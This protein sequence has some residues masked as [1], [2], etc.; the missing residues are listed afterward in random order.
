MQMKQA[1][2]VSLRW[3]IVLPLFS[4]VLIIAMVGAYFLANSLSGNIAV[5]QTNI[6]MESSRAVSQRIAALY[7]RQRIEAQG[8][9]FTIGVP[10]AITSGRAGALYPSM[11]AIASRA[12]LDSIIVT[13]AR[14]MEIVGIQR[15]D[16]PDQTDYAISTE[17]DLSNEIII[18]SVL[19]DGYIGATGLMNTTEGVLLFTA[20]PVNTDNEIIGV[21]LVG[22]RIDRVISEIHDGAI[23]DVALYGPDA[24]LM[25]SSFAPNDSIS[26]ALALNGGLFDQASRAVQNI[27]VQSF[28]IGKTLYQGAYFPFAFGPNIL[29]VIG[30]VMPDNI[31]FATEMGRQLT[32]LMLAS[33]AAV[34]VVGLFVGVNILIARMNRITQTA[35][36]L[37]AGNMT[38]RTGMK[39]TDEIGALGQALDQY[40]DYVQGRQDILRADLRRQ[41]RETT[42]LLAVLESLPD[43]IVVQD[44]DGRV[45]LMND[46]AKTLIGS[47]HISHSPDLH[48]LI[49]HVTNVLGPALAPGLYS[50]GSPQQID[51]D[52]KMLSAQA[53]AVMSLTGQRVGTVVVIR[54]ITTD[55]QRER[56]RDKILT[57]IAQEIQQP[58]SALS[59]PSQ[60]SPMS[61][62]AREITRHAVALQKM[63]VEMRELADTNLRDMPEQR[64]RPIRLDT[65]VWSVANEWRQ[66]A[67]ANNLTLHV[68]IEKA[69][70]HVLGNERRLRWAIGNIIDNAIKYT[71]PGGALTLEIRDDISEGRAHLRVRDNGVGIPSD[72]L[73]NVLTRFYRGN[74]IT[75]EGRAI[76]VPGTGQGLSSA[77][78]IFEAH[79]GALTIKSKQWVGTAVYFTIPLTAPVGLEIPGLSADMEGE[80]VRIETAK[81][82]RLN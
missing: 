20:V 10:E 68:I 13:D 38:A 80:T 67:Q 57:Q 47:Q 76:R 7:E 40:A 42:H 15:V 73:P 14:G 18:D 16:D 50:L 27:P 6:L 28:Q 46:K 56:A 48:E 24:S 44:T 5:S 75:K 66:V 22:Q 58:L 32:S 33:L 53:A 78:Q 61:E 62:F 81:I 30:V 43:G 35:E 23:A 34:V 37:T 60:R 21:A 29:G 71:T 3:R 69:G 1:R 36:A 59:K 54:D 55:V 82:N 19:E 9:A 45:M 72:E 52:G 4:A 77:K 63:V 65:L 17:T 11:E 74:P 26:S 64:Q 12:G 2:F 49:A 41:R 31:P 39:A 25:Q 70:L 79:G 8:I 51:M